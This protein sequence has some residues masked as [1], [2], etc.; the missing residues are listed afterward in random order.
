[1]QTC[2]V[3]I[4]SLKSVIKSQPLEKNSKK[5][6]RRG[7]FIPDSRVCTL[8][9]AKQDLWGLGGELACCSK[10]SL[11]QHDPP[12]QWENHFGKTG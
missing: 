6:K 10:L 12:M 2:V 4:K 11:C 3:K 8:G 9:M 7:I 5:D 1:M